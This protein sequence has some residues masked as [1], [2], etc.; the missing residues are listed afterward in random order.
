MNSNSFPPHWLY[1]VQYLNLTCHS[2][3]A[4]MCS[5]TGLYWMSNN[6]SRS[7]RWFWKHVVVIN[8]I[9]ATIVQFKLVNKLSRWLWPTITFFQSL[10]ACSSYDGDKMLDEVIP[11]QY[12]KLIKQSSLRMMGRDARRPITPCA[13][14]TQGLF[15]AMIRKK[16]CV[17]KLNSSTIECFPT[18]L[19]LVF[20]G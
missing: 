10:N 7:L 16:G 3:L 18:L 6:R 20:D 14:L 19:S 17:Q 9:A 1:S 15:S 2:E 4:F 12:W 11:T 5:K 8:F 13:T